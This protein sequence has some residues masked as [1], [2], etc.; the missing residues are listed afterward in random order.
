MYCHECHKQ[1]PDNFVNC[2][3][4]GAKL[5]PEKKK[6]PSHF[7]SKRKLKIKISFK[8]LI[9][10]LL[11]FATVITVAAIFTATVT[12]SKPERVVKGFVRAVQSQDENLYYS[13]YDDGIK[14]Y[15]KQNRYYAD[16]ETFNNM[17]APLHESK[18]FYTSR[19]GENYKLSYSVES[20]RT[21][22]ETELA[23][24]N[25]MLESQFS[26]INSASRVDVMS[27]EIHAKGKEGE[28]N[29]LYNDFWCMKIKGKWYK[30]DKTIYTEYQKIETT[31]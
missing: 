27:V 3:Y 18:D 12:G 8:T 26:Y 16:D 15:K 9:A 20:S 6:T 1:S 21:L 10:V 7:V 30:V 17:V 28:Y 19:C 23:A 13:L 11:V 25:K 14:E 31:V 2:A 24:F 22:S 29:S 5:K 4:C